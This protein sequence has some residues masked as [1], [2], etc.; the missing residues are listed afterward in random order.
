MSTL[1][2]NRKGQA[3]GNA[4]SVREIVRSE[5]AESRVLVHRLYREHT[6]DAIRAEI[7]RLVRRKSDPWY[8]SGEKLGLDK[9]S[10]SV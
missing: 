7:A 2:D 6:R 3:H 9:G 8:H 4:P 1:S 5:S 10:R